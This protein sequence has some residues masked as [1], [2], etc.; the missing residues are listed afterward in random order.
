M[1]GG[2]LQPVSERSMVELRKRAPAFPAEEFAREI[3]LFQIQRGHRPQ[4]RR[5][6]CD[7]LAAIAHAARNLYDLLA[8]RSEELDMYLFEE[9]VQFGQPSL[10]QDIQ[11]PLLR[12]EGL[13]RHAVNSATPTVK[14]GRDRDPITLFVLRL[15]D[16]LREGGQTPDASTN[17]P[18]VVAF[19]IACEELGIPV[20][21]PADTVRKKLHPPTGNNPAK[22]P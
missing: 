11:H 15:A 1:P 10:V 19:G 9:C 14:P 4:P 3:G 7:D 2:I 17:G 12:L 6:V 22:N 5:E 13:S 16:I 18:L 20:A 21:D 8:S